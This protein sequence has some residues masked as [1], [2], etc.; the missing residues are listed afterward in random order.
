M[1]ATGLSC[2]AGYTLKVKGNCMHKVLE[3][4]PY[5][6]KM[7]VAKICFFIEAYKQTITAICSE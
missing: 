4:K 3:F 5:T 1:K 7:H 6:I 2:D